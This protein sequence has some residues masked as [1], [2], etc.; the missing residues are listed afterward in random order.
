VTP[1]RFV[2]LPAIAAAV[3]V[4]AAA[5]CGIPESSDLEEIDPADLAGLDETTTTTTTTTT[6]PPTTAPPPPS[7]ETSPVTAP[8]TTLGPPIETTTTLATEQVQL[9][10]LAGSQLVSVSQTLPSQPSLQQVLLSL[11]SGPPT[12]DVGVG[13]QS[14]VPAGLTNEVLEIGGVATVDVSEEVFDTIA[15]TDQRAMFGQIVLTLTARP[16]V[17][18]VRFTLA[19]GQEELSVQKRSGELSEPGEAVSDVEFEPL[20]D[21]PALP[22]DISTDVSTSAPSTTD[23]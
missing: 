11:E 13:L 9:Y 10:Y 20:V 22:P 23:E 12:G 16:G 3:A 5:S 2:S 21:D 14:V 1:S 15:D 6:T 4:V 7:P 8:S 18:Q 19:D 17:G